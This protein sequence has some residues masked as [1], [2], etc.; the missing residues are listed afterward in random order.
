MRFFSLDRNEHIRLIY[1]I[2]NHYPYIKGEVIYMRNFSW[3]Y[4]WNTGEIDAYLL[5]KEYDYLSQIEENND[6]DKDD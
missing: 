5:Y 4:F 2:Y 6:E 3:K 1:N